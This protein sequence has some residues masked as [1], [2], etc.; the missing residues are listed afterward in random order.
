VKRPFLIAAMLL[1]SSH[2][3]AGSAY[4]NKDARIEFLAADVVVETDKENGRTIWVDVGSLGAG[5]AGRLYAN[6][7][8]QKMGITFEEPTE[9]DITTVTDGT[10]TTYT[11]CK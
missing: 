7:S 3:M 1:A 4:C 10:T 6:V 8:D 9:S 11:R 2:A 5:V